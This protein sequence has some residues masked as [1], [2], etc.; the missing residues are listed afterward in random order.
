MKE[1]GE[2]FNEDDFF[3]YA[4][5]RTKDEYQSRMTYGDTDAMI[6]VTKRASSKPVSEEEKMAAIMGPMYYKK[7]KERE[8]RARKAESEAKLKAEKDKE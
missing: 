2:E 4:N 5:T 7:K 1:N 8:E 3:S 6:D